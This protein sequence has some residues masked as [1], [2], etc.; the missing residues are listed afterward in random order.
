MGACVPDSP[1]DAC[2]TAGVVAVGAEG[3]KYLDA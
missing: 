3:S 2:W 1:V